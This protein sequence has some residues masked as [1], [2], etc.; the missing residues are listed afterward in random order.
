MKLRLLLN[1]IF[2]TLF[3]GCY[4]K[5]TDDS[6]TS[7]SSFV[8]K[9]KKVKN[10]FK[11]N[12]SASGTYQTGDIITISVTHPFKVTVTGTPV[13]P[14]TI[15]SGAKNA[16]YD[17]GS[18][19][20]T[21]KFKYT[22]VVADSDADGIEIGDI[23][24]SGGTITFQ[25]NGTTTNVATALPAITQ[26]ILID[27]TAPTITGVTLPTNGTY[28]YA[29]NMQFIL[30][31]SESVYVTGT[32]RIAM[33]IGA[34]TRYA[35]YHSGSGTENLIFKY[36]IQATDIDSNGI[37]VTSPIELNSGTI[38]D[39]AGNAAT[40]T[41]VPGSTAAILVEGDVPYVT[42]VTPPSDGTYTPGETLDVRLIFTENVTVTGVPR[43]PI[44]IGVTQVWANYVSGS[45]TSNILFRYTVVPGDVDTNGAQISIAWDN[46]SGTATIRDAGA[47]DALTTILPPS[48]PDVIIDAVLPTVT[49]ITAP[50]NDTYI[51]N[52]ELFF[53]LTF[54]DQV[55]VTGSPRL[56]LTVGATTRYATY[57][58]GSGTTSLIFRYQVPSGD[59]DLDG[60][61][62]GST[63]DLN[64]G[65]IQNTELT[66]ADTDITIPLALIS[67]TSVLVDA[68][69]PTI[70]SVT[71]D[72]ANGVYSSGTI[73]LTVNFSE[74]VTITSSPTIA[75]N[76]GG[77]SRNATCSNQA[78]VTS[79]TCSYTLANELDLDGVTMTAAVAGGSIVDA[80]GNSLSTNTFSAPNGSGIQIINSSF[81]TWYIPSSVYAYTDSTCTTPVSGNGDPIACLEDLTG[82]GN[83]ATQTSGGLEPTYQSSVI[84]SKP[85][86]RFNG[87]TQYLEDALSYTARAVFIVFKPDNQTGDTN[88][89]LWGD[90][91]GG[92]Q[93]AV[94]NDTGL[95]SK[96]YSFDGFGGATAKFAKN[97]NA[98]SGFVSDSAGTNDWSTSAQLV[99]VEFNAN[100]GVNS[101]TIGAQNSGMYEFY[102]GDIAEIIILSSSPSAGDI[103]KIKT[104]LN[105]K[106]SLY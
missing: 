46:N 30:E 5:T 26:E 8:S 74:A 61:A 66:N 69:V 13:I 12:A 56:T 4:G 51:Y 1:L 83:N 49:S 37:A 11:S 41:F 19:T 89:Q 78:S 106:Y 103:T 68:V 17:S 105:G 86:V 7:G 16:V 40:L 73:Q 42:S 20:T 101:Q 71:L 21:L 50:A 27:N 70:S 60:I 10:E 59:L 63:I 96:Y 36:A 45:G 18:G 81:V 47:K 92:H 33:T 6:D 95:V 79:T 62:L 72:T 44:I 34:T 58:S 35:T 38:L 90:Y 53:T 48:T 85:V 98:V 3:V 100:Q 77:T 54:N 65:S 88:G 15:D 87:S 23:N 91:N 9:H 14:L 57:S 55:N 76:I 67:L 22:I 39:Y 31:F 97:N 64:G 43:V 82:N 94:Y 32:P 75:L 24:L 102:G 28:L 93:V 29:K 99:Y 84:N 80:T 104:Y 52:E 25:Y 2:L